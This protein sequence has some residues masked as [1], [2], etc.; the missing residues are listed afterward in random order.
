MSAPEGEKLTMDE[1]LFNDVVG[2]T[3]RLTVYLMLDCSASMRGEPFEAALAG[4]Q[5]L[6]EEL[7]S[8]PEAR[9]RIHVAVITYAATVEHTAL[10][11]LRSFEPPTVNTDTLGLAASRL[12]SALSRLTQSI[13]ADVR[14]HTPTTKG[15]FRPLVFL[16]TAGGATDAYGAASAAYQA[17]VARIRSLR[18]NHQ[19]TLIAFGCG[20]DADLS[21]L[22]NITEH[23]ML[24]QDVSRATLRQFFPWRD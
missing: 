20:P 7:M 1:S 21:V 17:Q 12:D 19:P 18:G 2:S 4:V 3:R 10:I 23:A 14:P 13:E 6:Y 22:R 9:F 5:A 11:P 8:D 24:M 16:F 15:D